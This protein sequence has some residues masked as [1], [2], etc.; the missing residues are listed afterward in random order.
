MAMIAAAPFAQVGLGLGVLFKTKDKELKTLAGSGILPSSLAG[1]TE[2]ITYGILVPYKRTMIYVA[3][4]GAIGG[5]INGY[6]GVVGTG[7]AL[8]SFLSIPIFTPLIPYMVGVFT[9][10]IIAMV[11]TMVFGYGKK[12][13]SSNEHAKDDSKDSEK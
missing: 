2:I 9:S 8:P 6:L 12:A 3:V 7:F 11:L 1:T 4:A 10:L 5:A 13:M